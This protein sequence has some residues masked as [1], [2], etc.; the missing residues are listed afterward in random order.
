MLLNLLVIFVD[1]LLPIFLAAGVG[2]I[3]AWKTDIDPKHLSRV[4]FY[5]F[6]PTLMLS[7][8]LKNVTPDLPI[9]KIAFVVI[10]TILSVSGIVFLIG[11]LLGYDK[12]MIIAMIIPA[13]SMNTGNMGLPICLFVFGETGLI[14][15]TFVLIT[16]VTMTYTVGVAVASMGKQDIKTA[17]LGL[18]KLP[19]I[20]AVLL[21][22]VL[23][24]TGWSLPAPITQA[25]D[26]LADASI[27]VMLILLGMQLQKAN[28][29]ANLK[30]LSISV[31][32]RLILG[33]LLAFLFSPLA[34]VSGMAQQ[35]TTL[36]CGMPGAVTSTVLATE[37]DVKPSFVTAAVT[38]GT[39][40]SPLTLTPL[41][42]LVTQ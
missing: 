12:E 16:N 1:N 8:I 18:L 32:A 38:I 14:Y 3:L 26:L 9:G 11:K 13:L 17:L 20:Y 2:V 33:P 28:L 10:L 41:I 6:S 40:L 42:W 15:A 34:G 29:R 23:V 31:A 37:Y 39:I 24:F 4:L 7:L 36:Q 22:F 25:V 27:P 35:V 21:G 30:A 5:V 19:M